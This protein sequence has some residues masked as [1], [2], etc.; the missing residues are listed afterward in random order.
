MKPKLHPKWYPDAQVICACGNT[1]KVGATVPTIKTDVC[2]RC[3]PFF[4]GEQRIVDTAGQVD[5]F[6]SRLRAREER[7]REREARQESRT[8][9]EVM[10]LETLSLGA[11]LEKLLKGA[12]LE[13]VGDVLKAL[14]EKGDEGLTAIKGI[15]LEALATI[16]RS[17]R[18]NGF[19]LPGDA[20]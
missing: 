11:H 3:H 20:A 15:G 7:L 6:M 5:R 16:K 10:G 12:G 9:P 13:T 4:T 8:N 1:W 14:N 19:T 2:S 17:L 18:A